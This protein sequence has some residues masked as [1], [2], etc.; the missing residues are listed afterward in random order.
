MLPENFWQEL[1]I[2][3]SDFSG[4]NLAE[5]LKQDFAWFTAGGKKI[6]I[7]QLELVGANQLIE[8][9]K[10]EIIRVL[11]E[12]KSELALDV[13]FLTGIDLEDD[14]NYFVAD[15]EQTKKLLEKVL[16]VKFSGSCAQRPGLI[17]RKQII[18]LI[19]EELE[20]SK[21][22]WTIINNH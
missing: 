7:A 14:K 17:M 3:K 20:N 15:D 16:A 6:G 1:F 10:Q 9:R 11:E 13:I 12:I 8:Q 18:P 2:A 21:Y 19:K 22:L 5:R 4:A